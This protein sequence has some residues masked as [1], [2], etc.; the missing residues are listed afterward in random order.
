MQTMLILGL[1]MLRN[2]P[3]EVDSAFNGATMYPL[4]LIRDSR[5]RYDAGDDGQRC[6]H[7]G[8]NLSLQKP[9]FI[10]PQW[11]MHMSPSLP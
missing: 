2:E 3:Y 1:D 7:I 8:F 9:F 6:E 5:A 11:V 4:K 10:N